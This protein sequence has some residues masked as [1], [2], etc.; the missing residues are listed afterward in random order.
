MLKNIISFMCFIVICILMNTSVSAKYIIDNQ[1]EVANLNIDRTKPIIEVISVE[2]TNIGYEKYANKTHTISLEVKIKDRNIDKIFCDKDHIKVKVENSYIEIPNAQFTK[3]SETEGEKIYKIQLKDLNSNGKLK[4]KFLEGTAV[5]A[6]GLKND[7]V[8]IDTNI[9]IDNIAPNGI[10]NEEKISDGKVN[11]IINLSEGIR[12][13]DGWQV[14]ENKLKI[15]REF[16]NN[17]SYELPIMDYA[18]NKSIVNIDITKASYINL[19]YASHN[20]EVGWTFGHGNYDIA[21]KEAIDRNPIYKTEALAFNFNGN[22]EPDFVQAKAYVYTH[23]GEGAYCRCESSGILY[24]HGYNPNDGTYKSM[25]SNDLVTI[26]G[27]KYFQFSGGGINYYTQTDIYGNN[28]IPYDVAYKYPYGIS[29]IILK[30]K[31]YSE[32][33]I[34]YQIYVDEVGWTKVCSDGEECMYSESKPMSAFRI[35]LVPKTEKQYV[36]DTW[37]KDI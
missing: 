8:E 35:A 13:L 7:E 29:G 17:I 15:Q 30:L 36:L 22:L 5:D 26:Q 37:N 28:P 20:S 9:L 27:E 33:S 6:G 19:T 4:V 3:I 11:G 23:W 21:G 18:G 31:D 12:Q 14:S 10:F 1:F 2:N 25:N 16:T 34:I 24:N 32:F